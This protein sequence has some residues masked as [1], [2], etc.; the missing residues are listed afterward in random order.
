[1][2]PNRDDQDGLIMAVPQLRAALEL[3][4]LR[5]LDYLLIGVVVALWALLLRFIWRERLFERLPGG[6]VSWATG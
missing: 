3:T 6:K 2:Q 4:P 5:G 1:L